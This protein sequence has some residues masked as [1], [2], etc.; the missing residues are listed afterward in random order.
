MVIALR[1]KKRGTPVSRCAPCVWSPGVVVVCLVARCSRLPVRSLRCLALRRAPVRQPLRSVRP[2]PRP[3]PRAPSPPVLAS[4]P[5]LFFTLR[6]PPPPYPSLLAP[7]RSPL[8]LQPPSLIPPLPASPFTAPLSFL[9]L[10]L[11][12]P[13]P[14]PPPCHPLPNRRKAHPPPLLMRRSEPPEAP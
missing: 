7:C 8:P 12:S 9:A 10:S 1:V 4:A 13:P 11:Y 3:R 6:A 2:V 14:S 5:P